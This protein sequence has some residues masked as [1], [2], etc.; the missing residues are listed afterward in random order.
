MTKIVTTETEPARVQRMYCPK[1][2]ESAGRIGLLEGGVLI[3]LSI[4]CRKCRKPFR[5]DTVTEKGN[6]KNG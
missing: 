3:G 4:S 6:A 5:A 2:G 1:C